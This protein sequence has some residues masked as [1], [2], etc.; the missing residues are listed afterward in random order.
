MGVWV[1]RT[2]REIAAAVH[3]GSATPREVALEHLDQIDRLDPQ[4]GAFVRVR[5]ERAV[6]EAEAVG[7]RG[8]LAALPL[9]G[10]PVAIKD[11]IPV[12]GEPT[13][14]GATVTDDAPAPEDHEVVR[15]LR[16]AGAVVVGITRMPELGVWATSDDTDGVARNP[17]SLDR[18]AGGSS[19]GS[20][21]AVAAAMV[22][23]AHGNDGLGSIRIPAATCGLVGIKPGADVVPSS[24][25][26]TSW[27]GLSE[28]GPLATTVADAALMLSVMAGRPEL[29]QV[30][31]PPGRLTIAAS[32]MVPLPGVRVDPEIVKAV[33]GAAAAL[34][35]AGHAIVRA[36]PPYSQS[37]AGAI[38]AWY[39]ASTA[40]EV[41][42]VDEAG[43]EPR[44]RRHAQLG[45]TL[46]RL[47]RVRQSDRDR[48]KERVARFFA[49]HDVLVTPVTTTMAPPAL[50]WR[51][52]S[53]RA[54][55]WTNARWAPFPGVW[56]F[57]QCPAA[58]VPVAMHSCGMP[59][60]IQLV[61]PPGGEALLL[62]VAGQ[63][64]SQLPWPRHAPL[65]GPA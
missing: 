59:I 24:V 43:L 36:D 13:L 31:P 44:Q 49:S 62:S 47:G 56:N 26:L 61:A 9:A 7:A 14:Y 42:A 25:G 8:D 50:A 29:A 35:R 12:A 40:D 17:W 55:F 48:W 41:A 4:V 51:D 2:A 65:A 21:A 11:N 63:L 34:Q 60:G 32:T 57:A 18:T 46:E 3:R 33:V 53:W 10:V 38:V 5:S 1:G 52:R 6:A 28:N 23:A 39:T 45:R 19:G 15:R 37:T 27:R 30:T 54:N 58:T 16:A 22:P 20:A 64:E